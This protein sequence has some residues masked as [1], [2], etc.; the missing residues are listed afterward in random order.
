MLVF[1]PIVE[2]GVQFD[3]YPT[4]IKAEDSSFV[5]EGKGGQGIPPGKYRVEIQQMANPGTAA[6]PDMNE[7]F[8]KD[9]SKIIV[10]VTDG[11]TPLVIDLAKA[12]N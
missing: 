2:A 4:R 6:I 8:G 11:K 5:L 9:T 12:G 1:I 3:S 7:R 10:E